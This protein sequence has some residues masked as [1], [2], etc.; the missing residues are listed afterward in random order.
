MKVLLVNDYG[1]P[2]GGAEI[3]MLQLRDVLR[4]R[5]HEALLFASSARR[6][7]GATSADV[8]CFGTTSRYRTLVQS[9][10]P[11]A[12]RG[13]RRTLESFAPDV[14]HVGLCLTQLSPLILPLLRGRPSVYH[15]HWLRAICPTGSKLLPDGAHCTQH[16]GV[17]CARSGCVPFR[18]WAPMLG[19]MTLWNQWRDAFTR[20]VA[21]SHATRAAL[22][23]EGFDDVSVI[24]CGVARQTRIDER[25]TA[26]TV[27]F[28]G[29]LARQKG[30]HVLLDAWRAVVQAIPHARLLVA[31]DGPDR[32]ALERDAPAGVTF[33]GHLTSVELG[34]AA[35]SAWVQVVPS[36]G[37]EGFGLAAVE[38][39][40]RGIAVVA[41]RTG[42]LAEVV[43]DG[44]TGALV[45]PNDVSS[46]AGA[47]TTLLRDRP[48]CERMG[49][50]G[51]A[52]AEASFSADAY[53]D[54]F[55][56]LYETMLGDAA[57]HA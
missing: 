5:G 3:A 31:G 50:R 26:P 13:L 2:D 15:A 17:A 33:M 34:R 40:M 21:N 36:I 24:P 37:F 9:A 39:M 30:I 7:D 53:V 47:I 38:A 48:A 19:Q 25:A 52:R 55:I 56:T 46:L 41:T 45:P 23:A 22:E 27:L 6:A 16:A 18:D 10:N 42:G 44:V 8:E 14:V 35:D 20:V 4:A 12:W 43:N 11:A 29:R 57:V 28:A 54:G 32:A 49:T 51:Q 1:S